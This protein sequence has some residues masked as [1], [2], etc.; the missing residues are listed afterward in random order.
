MEIEVPAEFIIDM[1]S[2]CLTEHAPIRG[3]KPCHCG[4]SIYVYEDGF[5]R[6]MCQT[7]SEER[8]DSPQDGETYNCQTD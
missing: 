8:C 5:T 4:K 1:C 6:F 2:I 7:C 3:C